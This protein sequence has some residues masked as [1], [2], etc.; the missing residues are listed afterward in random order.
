MKKII[1]SFAAL[2]EFYTLSLWFSCRDFTDFLNLSSINLKLHLTALITNDKGIAPFIVRIYHN[3][4]V[5][6]FFNSF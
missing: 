2:V 5:D 6:F 1:I 3:K 4:I